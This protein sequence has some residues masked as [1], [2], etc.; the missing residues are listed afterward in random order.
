MRPFIFR[1]AGLDKKKVHNIFCF[2]I[3]ETGSSD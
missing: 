1:K 2:R 3:T